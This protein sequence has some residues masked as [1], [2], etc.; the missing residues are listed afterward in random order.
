MNIP[1]LDRRVCP[2]LKA[3]AIPTKRARAYGSY[4]TLGRARLFSLHLVA[5]AVPPFFLTLARPLGLGSR[6]GCFPILFGFHFGGRL[7]GG[8]AA[9]HVLVNVF[10][11]Q[12]RT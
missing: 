5:V 6:G 2:W 11:R 7:L 8:R 9:R 12:D 1:G 4:E 3:T 10:S